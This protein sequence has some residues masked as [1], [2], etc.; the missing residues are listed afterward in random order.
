LETG[1]LGYFLNV[2]K[3][4]IKNSLNDVSA[5][6]KNTV[7]LYVLRKGKYHEGNR[8]TN[9]YKDNRY[10]EPDE[11]AENADTLAAIIYHIG[12]GGEYPLISKYTLK[13]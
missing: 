9:K 2:K 11:A 4:E 12:N 10:L 1:R 8:N 6:K 13:Q 7:P 5:G 3:S